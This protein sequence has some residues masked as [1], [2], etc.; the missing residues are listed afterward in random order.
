MTNKQQLLDSIS[1]I[2]K[3]AMLET[4]KD[5]ILIKLGILSMMVR[6]IAGVMEEVNTLNGLKIQ[7]ML[8]DRFENT[9]LFYCQN[10]ICLTTLS[11]NEIDST[12]LIEFIGRK[13]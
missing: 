3:L 7:M 10:R 8:I 5:R 4:L 1:E 12:D 9:K 13:D 11:N 6:D 2:E